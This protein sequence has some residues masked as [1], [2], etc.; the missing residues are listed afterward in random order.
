MLPFTPT[1]MTRVASLGKEKEEEKEKRVSTPM[2]TGTDDHA[3]RE[4]SGASI[5][6]TH[7]SSF[8]SPSSPSPLTSF[9]SR[10][11]VEDFTAG[12]ETFPASS[13]SIARDLSGPWLV[14]LEEEMSK[15]KKNEK[16]QESDL[17]SR[18]DD[19]SATESDP[20]S[21]SGTPQEEKEAP[22]LLSG[23][24]YVEEDGVVFYRPS[25][26][27]GH[28]IGK[29]E[30]LTPPPSVGQTIPS[31]LHE[32]QHKDRRHTKAS[33]ASSNEVSAE[34]AGT[35]FKMDLD[36][37]Q[38]DL[39]DTEPPAR[40]IRW[41]ISGVVNKVK[42][43][44][45]NYTTFSLLG[46]WERMGEMEAIGREEKGKG[47]ASAPEV[48]KEEENHSSANH[49]RL[50]SS[51]SVGLLHAAKV[52]PWEEAGMSQ[53]K[54]HDARS[55]FWEPRQDVQMAFQQVFPKP[56][57]LTSHLL[58]SKKK[59]EEMKPAFSCT[60]SSDT[61]SEEQ[62]EMPST[63]LPSTTVCGGHRGVS[64]STPPHHLDLTPFR[65][66]PHI[67]ELYYIPNYISE[68]EEKQIIDLVQNTPEAF[69][70]KL[71]KRTCQEWGGSLCEACEKSFVADA[72]VPKW[73]QQTMDMQ[74]YDGIFTPT[75]FPNS[76]R[77]HE[78]Q[79]D[80]GI[81][82][83][84][85]GP[86]YIPLVTVLSA[87][88]TSV[89][90]FYPPNEK[91]YDDPMQHYRDTFQFKDGSIGARKP[92][93]SV[94]LEPR[95]L[96]IFSG[97]GG[98]Y[99]Y[100]H[101]IPADE[102][103][104]DLRHCAVANRLLLAKENQGMMEVQRQYR[105]SITTRHLLSRCHHQPRRVEY[106]MK[107]ASFLYGQQPIPEPLFSRHIFSEKPSDPTLRR[108]GAS[109]E[110][111]VEGATTVGGA[112]CRRHSSSLRVPT[113]TLS[114]DGGSLSLKTARSLEEKLDNVLHEQQKLKEE[115]Q[116]VQHMLLSVVSSSSHFQKEV[117]EVLNHL[118]STMLDV[119]AKAEDAA[120]WMEE[121]NAQKKK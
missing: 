98:Y 40:S 24:L 74:V 51:Y 83:H 42:S 117:S 93:L 21:H 48:E 106:M 29:I 101:G 112:D 85:D 58:R 34:D 9:S 37:Y 61:A 41:Q 82:P 90:H 16:P 110:V 96:L 107:R 95:S 69:K 80:E 31:F 36:V 59:Q 70:S 78:Y 23:E 67:S 15:G 64:L 50:S 1:T 105:V 13:V 7:S 68:E 118:T 109:S 49:S 57:A 92:L 102:A 38:F 114:S 104:I 2:T 52:M 20:S 47:M 22:P 71:Q 26:Q 25:Q 32:P 39:R 28:G 99:T 44:S 45:L 17:P 12:I 108:S 65:I 56:L 73:V 3:M 30:L 111:D 66:A 8:H 113:D 81:G 43:K 63:S 46:I 121:Q 94:V 87:A 35:A 33:D 62:A 100:P 5:P 88:S 18:T 116:Q 91:P 6:S 10:H 77:I 54:H 115:L 60:S 119:Q 55:G 72:N 76:V 84:T 120:D 75:T 103:T 11:A 4:G 97:K 53:G 89:M 14:M 79:T 19:D 27:C 86:I